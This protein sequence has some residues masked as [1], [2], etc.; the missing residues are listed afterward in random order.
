MEG[1]YRLFDRRCRT[2]PA[3]AKLA[4]LQARLRRLG[5]LREA[6]R[7]LL[8]PGLEQALGVPGRAAALPSRN[9]RILLP[10]IRDKYS[11]KAAWGAKRGPL[12]VPLPGISPKPL[13][14]W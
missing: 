14:A 1:V 9:S 13:P 11:L 3:L 2:A 6:L 12:V 10:M 4:T 8:A 7:N 5:W